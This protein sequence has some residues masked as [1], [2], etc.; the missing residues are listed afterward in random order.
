[1]TIS[2]TGSAAFFFS[3]SAVYADLDNDGDLDLVVNNIDDPA[4][5]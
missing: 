5:I 3:N 1:L 4:F 2:D